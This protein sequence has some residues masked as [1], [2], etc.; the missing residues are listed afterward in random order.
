MK[1][2]IFLLLCTTFLFAEKQPVMLKV[3]T[4]ITLP[5]DFRDGVEEALTS[6]NKSLIN[7]DIQ[8][9]AL[10]SQ[11]IDG[12]DGCLDDSCLIDTGKMLAAKIIIIIDVD[13]IDD[14]IKSSFNIVFIESFPAAFFL[15]GNPGCFY[16]FEQ[17]FLYFFPLPQGHG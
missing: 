5:A 4:K 12:E 9:E 15:T 1:L 2:F 11:G 6:N 14:K 7:E 8:K 17:H 10:E 3:K 16:L 13:Q